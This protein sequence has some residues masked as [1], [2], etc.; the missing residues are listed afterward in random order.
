MSDV[1]KANEGFTMRPYAFFQ[2]EGGRKPTRA[3]TI[4]KGFLYSMSRGGRVCHCGYTGLAEKFHIAKS[5]VAR[6]IP[7]LCAG[8]E[9]AVRRRG[10]KVSQYTYVGDVGQDKHIRTENFF[11]TETFDIRGEIRYLTNAEVD[12]LSLIYTHTLNEKTRCFSGSIRD[13]AGLLNI[14]DKTVMRAIFA[15]FAAD[16]IFRPKRGLNRHQKS[17]FVANLKKLQAYKRK[18]KREEKKAL[19]TSYLPKEAIDANA[20]AEWQRFYEERRARAD[21]VAL[22]FENQAKS[23]VRYRE[24]AKELAGMEIK[25]AKAELYAPLTVPALMARQKALQVERLERLAALGLED[26]QLK[27][28]YICKKCSDTGYL[29]NGRVCDCYHRE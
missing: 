28:D 1:V 18:K 10:G 2:N 6:I 13:I 8:E 12:V 24:I 19:E 20:R 21:A 14:S 16:L 7:S 4:L 9:V 3:E 5:T 25:L 11:Y 22:R 15:L 17:E 27:P 23:D 26:W 29:P